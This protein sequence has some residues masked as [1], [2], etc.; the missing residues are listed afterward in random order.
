[1]PLHGLGAK[2]YVVR[3]WFCGLLFAHGFVV[4]FSALWRVLAFRSSYLT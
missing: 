1:M 4:R 3:V 2:T